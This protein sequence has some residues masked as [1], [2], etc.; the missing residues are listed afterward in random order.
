MVCDS[1]S[2]LTPWIQGTKVQHGDRPIG[3][4]GSEPHI[5]VGQGPQLY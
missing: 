2:H 1:S 4:T 5:S 3:G